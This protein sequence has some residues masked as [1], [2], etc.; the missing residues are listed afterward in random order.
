MRIFM[1][2]TTGQLQGDLTD[3]G[4]TQRCI[5]AL[6]DFLRQIESSERK[7]RIDCGKILRADLNG[8]RVL[9]TWMQCARLRGVELELINP[10]A[11]LWQVMQ[12]FALGSCFT[13]QAA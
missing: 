7:I 3:S 10:S 5:V 2:G 4:V 13:D 8:L 11:C 9:Y 6:A 1:N 12:S